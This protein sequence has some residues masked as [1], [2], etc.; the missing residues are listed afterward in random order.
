MGMLPRYSG[1]CLS[2]IIRKLRTGLALNLKHVCQALN[3]HPVNAL[4]CVIT[5]YS[6]HYTKLYEGLRE[7]VEV[8]DAEE[9]VVLL[10]EPHPVLHRAE[11]VADMK[12]AGRLNAGEDAGHG[13]TTY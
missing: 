10:L 9:A 2:H 3:N 5:S 12:L 11:I 8:D 1:T 7:G 13:V 4:P 6:I